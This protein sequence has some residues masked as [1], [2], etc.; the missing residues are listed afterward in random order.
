MMIVKKSK[1]T[2]AISMKSFEPDPGV[3]RRVEGHERVLKELEKA[4]LFKIDSWR[5]GGKS[6]STTARNRVRPTN[7]SQIITKAVWRGMRAY[8]AIMNAGNIR[9][10]KDYSDATWFSWSDLKEENGE[11]MA[12]DIPGRVLIEVIAYSRRGA[13]QDSPVESGGYF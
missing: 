11:V 4:H 7:G 10:N 8:C 1:H 9:R 5:T 2:K 13:I 6:F 12:V 3:A